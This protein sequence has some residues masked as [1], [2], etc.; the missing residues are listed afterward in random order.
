MEHVIQWVIDYK[1][2]VILPLAIIEGPVLSMICGFL[3]NLGYMAF[4][5]VY[6]SL[7]AADLIGDTIWYYVG[8]YGGEKFV[9][10]I[11]K[12]FG[13][14]PKSFEV[15]KH[16]YQK[17]HEYILLISKITMGLGFPF[18]VLAT[19]GIVK[20]PFR[21]YIILNV[22]GQFIWTGALI[23]IGYY[24]GNF[25]LKI[26]K[27]IEIVSFIALFVVIFIILVAFGRYIRA[28]TIKNFS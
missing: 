19:A 13:I 16:V 6:I 25:Y 23:A 20:I 15:I 22:I 21:R 12:Y 8:Y 9:H 28:R 17:Y 3:L 14:T 11:G 10:K 24:L 27:G 18:V 2:I 4:V 5:P 26:N 7:M 1:Y